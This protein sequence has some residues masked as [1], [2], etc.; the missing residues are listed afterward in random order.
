MVTL[1]NLLAIKRIDH[2]YCRYSFGP[3]RILNRRNNEIKINLTPLAFRI[4]KTI[5][6]YVYDLQ[7]TT[8]SS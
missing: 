5:T 7:K 1:K 3:K 6:L 4:K 2:Y 8:L